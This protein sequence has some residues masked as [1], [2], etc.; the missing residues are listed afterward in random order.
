[1]RR[2]K[3]KKASGCLNVT[4]YY[5]SFFYA[6]SGKKLEILFRKSTVFFN[7]PFSCHLSEPFGP[8]TTNENREY[9]QR[10]IVSLSLQSI[11]EITGESQEDRQN[12]GNDKGNR[13]KTQTKM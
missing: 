1:M 9:K 7:E 4:F 6:A 11:R 2:K 8:G 12:K 13:Y 10:V 5:S 3:K